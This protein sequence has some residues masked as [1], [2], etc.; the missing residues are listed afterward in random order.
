MSTFSDA[1]TGSVNTQSA[2]NRFEDLL[3]TERPIRRL[4]PR[5]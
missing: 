1:E 4:R 5:A 2:E 3:S